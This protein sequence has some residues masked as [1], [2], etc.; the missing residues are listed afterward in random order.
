MV[1][2]VTNRVS[3]TATPASVR[4]SSKSVNQAPLQRRQQGLLII[5]TPIRA[6]AF[7]GTL[8]SD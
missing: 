6:G 1:A 8:W 4:G 7:P 2:V 3:W 5:E